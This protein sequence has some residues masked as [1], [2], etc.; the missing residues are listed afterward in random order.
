M[1]KFLVKVN[2][3]QYEVEVEEVRNGVAT[4]YTPVVTVSPARERERLAEVLPKPQEPEE[5]AVNVNHS[6]SV[7][8]VG[9]VKIPSPMPGTILRIVANA[10]DFIKR[11][12]VLV[13]L[14]AMKMEN[15]IVAPSDGVVVSINVSRGASVNAG[16]VLAT[17]N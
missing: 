15:E 8:T 4:A 3:N 1:K 14:E 16:D 12:Q 13:I 17:L 6:A 5:K 9:S 11:G 7:D 2:G 10:G